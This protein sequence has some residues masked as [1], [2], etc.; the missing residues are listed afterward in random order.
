LLLVVE[1]SGDTL[2]AYIGMMRAPTDGLGIPRSRFAWAHPAS[3]MARP[4]RTDT[5]VSIV[6]SDIVLVSTFA[7]NG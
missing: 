1:C 4:A 3:Q 6:G 2:L 5:A 7:Q